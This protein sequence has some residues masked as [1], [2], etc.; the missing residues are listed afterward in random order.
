MVL[1][2][3]RLRWTWALNHNHNL[4]TNMITQRGCIQGLK[5][6][7]NSVMSSSGCVSSMTFVISSLFMDRNAWQT[8]FMR[9][10]VRIMIRMKRRKGSVGI[11][12]RLNVHKYMMLCWVMSFR[13][14]WPVL[15]ILQYRKLFQTRLFNMQLKTWNMLL[16]DTATGLMNMMVKFSDYW[17]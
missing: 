13:H 2:C 10:N 7:T 1:L 9:V 16:Q 6:G 17:L 12:R 3:R 15:K 11:P 8:R 4:C 5:F 14:V